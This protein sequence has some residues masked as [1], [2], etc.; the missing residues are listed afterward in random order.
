M[1]GYFVL[2]YLLGFTLVTLIYL[3]VLPVLLGYRRYKIVLITGVS[4]P[5]PSSPSFRMSCMLAFRRNCRELFSPVLEGVVIQERFANGNVAR[6]VRHCLQGI[7]FFICCW[8][9]L[10]DWWWCHAGSRPL[11]G[12]GLMLPFTFG[13]PPA[14]AII[15]LA[16]V[17]AAT[18]YGTQSRQF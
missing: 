9:Q 7:T 15:F 18:A 10:S 2:I 14:T 4:R 5:R 12:V 1:V 17:H 11:F 13:M 3:L 8:G 16:A 6:W